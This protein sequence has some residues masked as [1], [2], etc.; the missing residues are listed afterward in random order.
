[1][2]IIFHWNGPQLYQ[3]LIFGYFH[4]VLLRVLPLNIYDNDKLM[5][6]LWLN[7]S[8]ISLRWKKF[9]QTYLKMYLRNKLSQEKH[10]DLALISIEQEISDKID[11]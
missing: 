6:S 3:R 7:T 1:M 5:N 10:S 8:N 4:V 2:V 11:H 9:L